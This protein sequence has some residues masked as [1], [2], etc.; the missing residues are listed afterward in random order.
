MKKISVASFA[1]KIMVILLWIA[2]FSVA[3]PKTENAL[4][5]QSPME[6][7]QGFCPKLYDKYKNEIGKYVAHYIFAVDVS[8]TMKRFEPYVVP[9]LKAFFNAL[10][11]GDMVTVIPFGTEIL[12]LPGYAGTINATMR[13]NLIERAQDLYTNSNLTKEFMRHTDIKKAVEAVAAA[14]RNNRDYKI[15]I[16]VVLTDFRN[17]VPVD[18]ERPLKANEIEDLYGGFNA[19][20]KGLYTRNIALELPYIDARGNMSTEKNRSMKGYCLNQLRDKV[21]PQEGDGKLQTV[22]VGNSPEAINHWFVQLQRDIM[23]TKLQAVIHLENNV[24]PATVETEVDIDGNVI[25]KV[26]WTPTR[27]YPNL[28]IDSSYFESADWNFINDEESWQMTKD[29]HI[30]VKLGQVKHREFGF[31]SNSDSLKLGLSLPTEYDNELELLNIKKPIPD[32]KASIGRWLFTFPLPLWLCCV[33][34][35]AI[36]WYI[37]MFMKAVKRNASLKLS[38]K[39][40]LIDLATEEEFDVSKRMD[41]LDGLSIP[42]SAG[43][44]LPVNVPWSVK[45]YKKKINPFLLFG[46]PYF[47]WE[48][49][50]NY[51]FTRS[52]TKGKLAAGINT[53][54][55]GPRPKT[56]SATHQLKIRRF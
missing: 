1:A 55:A 56:D 14:V 32:T 47:M 45:I 34:I 15:N 5:S 35:A 39:V 19:A 27:L 37:I 51:V 43:I 42:G 9:S 38:C 8:G 40:V 3:A 41:K 7:L 4:A 17:D 24:A 20:I 52:G 53:L 46:D 26:D 12:N 33:I 13:Q 23:V 22:P 2:G 10:P 28:K 54:Y 49:Q 25:A 6:Y 16:L 31:H 18:K 48:S 44:K 50:K 30:E 36:L 11:D 29:Q 21:F